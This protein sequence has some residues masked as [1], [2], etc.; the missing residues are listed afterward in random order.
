MYVVFELDPA[1]TIQDDFAF[2][3]SELNLCQATS[4]MQRECSAQ[5]QIVTATVSGHHLRLATELFVLMSHY[6]IRNI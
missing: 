5:Y 3:V 4:V 2:S 6:K 1:A